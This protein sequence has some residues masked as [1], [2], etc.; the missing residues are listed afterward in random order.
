[1]ARLPFGPRLRRTFALLKTLSSSQ[2]PC[3]HPVIE[4]IEERLK[5][6]FPIE[7]VPACARRCIPGGEKP[8]HS[9]QDRPADQH[10]QRWEVG[11]EGVRLPPRLDRGEGRVEVIRKLKEQL[12]KI[13]VGASA[14]RRAI[15]ASYEAEMNV[16]IHARTGTLWVRLGDGRLDLEVSAKV[17]L[18]MGVHVEVPEGIPEDRQRIVNENCRTLKFQGFGFEEE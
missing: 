11:E 15:I 14:L 12:A 18:T 1:M 8:E 10:P 16:V 4:E 6:D 7:D 2:S 9:F 13:G 3:P 5:G 17:E